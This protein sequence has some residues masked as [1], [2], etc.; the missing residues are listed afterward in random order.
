MAKEKTYHITLEEG[1]V[2]RVGFGD[3]AQNDQIVRDAV[4]RL[5]EMVKSGEL[6]GGSLIKINGPASLPVAIAIGHAVVH[7]YEVVAVFDPKLGRYVV[8]V[9]HGDKYRPGDL[10]D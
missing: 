8:A 1:D 7:L 3:P 4:A 2:L 10:I 9:S 6:A 5:D